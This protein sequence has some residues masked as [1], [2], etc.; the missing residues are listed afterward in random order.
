M[1]TI[2]SFGS[3]GKEKVRVR[4][5]IVGGLAACPAGLCVAPAQWLAG[6][7]RLTKTEKHRQDGPGSNRGVE[8][9]NWRDGI[10]GLR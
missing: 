7:W 8:A 4:R 9:S 2:R 10:L 3:E 6:T 5:Q 1:F